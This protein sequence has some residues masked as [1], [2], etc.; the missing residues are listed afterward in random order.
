MS[1]QTKSKKTRDSLYSKLRGSLT[2]LALRELVKKF[3]MFSGG[4]WS[5]V[6]TFI[7]G[8]LLDK[9][10]KPAV[11]KAW[12]KGV[13]LKDIMKGRERAKEIDKAD[14]VDDLLDTLNG[15]K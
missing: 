4:A 14:N 10:L 8:Y 13:K 11:N 7:V 12:R 6:A 5:W 3:A 15:R 2:S 1:L 9:F